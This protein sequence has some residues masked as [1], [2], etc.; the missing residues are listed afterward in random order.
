[1]GTTGEHEDRRTWPVVAFTSSRRAA[2][3]A[4]K[5]NE[6]AADHRLAGYGHANRRFGEHSN[7]WDPRMS[8][9]YTG[10]RYYVLSYSVPLDP[11][12]PCR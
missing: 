5:A 3:W 4:R 8:V 2:A 12:L 11:S 7:P 9:D 10:V 6:W 1:M